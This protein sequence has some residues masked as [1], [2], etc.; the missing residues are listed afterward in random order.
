MKRVS[1]KYE[2]TIP[3]IQ[4]AQRRWHAA[5][6]RLMNGSLEPREFHRVLQLLYEGKF[7]EIYSEFDAFNA[8]LLNPA[9]Q[10][11]VLSTYN[12]MYWENYFD[13]LAFARAFELSGEYFPHYQRVD[14]VLVFH[15]EFESFEMA[16]E[17]WRR[18]F[19]AECQGSA[20]FTDVLSMQH[21]VFEITSS[22]MNAHQPGTIGL[23]RMN[24]VHDWS[25]EGNVVPLTCQ[26]RAVQ[27]DVT[28]AGLEVLSVFGIH[29]LLFGYTDGLRMPYPLLSNFS[30]LSPEHDDVEV[31]EP[32]RIVVIRHSPS[33]PYLEIYRNTSA[34]QSIAVPILLPLV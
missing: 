12:S 7:D 18:V 3:D 14:D 20:Y 17:M 5:I 26:L 28:L 31:A 15:P 33:G 6:E 19:E 16:I 27:N 22:E 11:E 1:Q 30:L 8:Y 34:L 21:Q 9:V 4:K 2:V 29:M 24:I 32:A 10:L 25:P 23:V 13:D